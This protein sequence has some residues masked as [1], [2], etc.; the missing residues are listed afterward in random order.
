MKKR[1]PQLLQQT[2]PEPS[3][4]MDFPTFTAQDARLLKGCQPVLAAEVD[5]IIVD[6]CRALS[7]SQEIALLRGRAVRLRRLK[8]IQRRYVLGLFSGCTGPEYVANRLRIS[9]IQQQV[10]LHPRLILA[11]MKTLKDLIVQALARGIGDPDLL[12]AAS[13]ALDRLLY[14]D[15]TLVFDAY[16][17]EVFSEVE[18]AREQLEERFAQRTRELD[19]K[20]AQLEAALASV[21]RLEGVLTICGVCKKIRNGEESWQQLEQY[22][23]Q[24]S[25]AMFSHGLCPECYEKM[26]G[27][28]DELAPGT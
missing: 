17:Q 21:K 13:Q 12:A 5:A 27:S 16:R 1:L 19:E 4:P 15:I 2:D 14:L 20:V 3:R 23:S 9:K 26:V 24:H 6:F 10:G 7:G 11:A 25:G 18:G 28:L 22:I 8:A